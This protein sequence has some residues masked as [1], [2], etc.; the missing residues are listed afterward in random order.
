MP[1]AS[2]LLTRSILVGVLIV[3]TTYGA[4]ALTVKRT[5][6]L[7]D[8]VYAPVLVVKHNGETTIHMIGKDGLTRSILF[9]KGRALAWARQLYGAEVVSASTGPDGDGSKASASDGGGY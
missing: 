1:F 4:S 2:T 9:N 7:I 8:G 6:T 3:S 5:T